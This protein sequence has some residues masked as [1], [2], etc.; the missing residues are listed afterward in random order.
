MSIKTIVTHISPDIDALTSVWLVQKFLPRWSSATVTFVPAGQT[1]NNADPDTASDIIHVDTGM[2]RF[3]HHDT[4]EET[5]AAEKVFDYLNEHNHI[6]TKYRVALE[7][8]IGL[9]IEA[10]HFHQVFYPDPAE[11]RYDL[12]LPSLLENLK[13]FVNSDSELVDES[14][15][16]L[17]AALMILVKKIDAES[18]IQQGFVF[19][20]L[21]GKS[22]ALETENT[23]SGRLAQRLGYQLVILKSLRAGYARIL[24]SPRSKKTLQRLYDTLMSQDKQATWFLHAS[25]HMLLNGTA[26]NPSYIATKLSLSQLISFVKKTRK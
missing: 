17:D 15:T 11:D 5:C 22:I 7:R 10:D 9:V 25:G 3:D 1:L 19:K 4:G 14:T 6:N 21:W 12:F 16:L 23:E 8:L 20:S 2:G 24:L 13:G 26:T 18:L